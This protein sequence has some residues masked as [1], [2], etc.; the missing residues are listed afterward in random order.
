MG[1][2]ISYDH[3]KFVDVITEGEVPDYLIHSLVHDYL[4]KLYNPEDYMFLINSNKIG[5]NKYRVT[6]TVHKKIW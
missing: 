5:D 1:K 6:F 4:G 2:V 3:G